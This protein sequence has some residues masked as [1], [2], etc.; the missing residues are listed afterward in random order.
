MKGKGK[1]R[2]LKYTV[3]SYICDYCREE[4]FEETEQWFPFKVYLWDKP[5]KTWGKEPKDLCTSCTEKARWKYVE[6]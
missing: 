3:P 4:I 5:T 2:T 6:A 1:T